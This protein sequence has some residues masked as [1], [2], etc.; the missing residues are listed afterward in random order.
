[1]TPRQRLERLY[2]HETVDRPGVYIRPGYPAGD[3]T[4]DR[5]R[6]YV[7]AHTE[8]KCWW[9]T[10]P[11]RSPLP[12]DVFTEP[13]SEDFER[14][15][16]VLHTRGGDLRESYLVSL[17]G[18]PGLRGEHLIKTVEDARRYLAMPPAQYGGDVSG[19][20]AAVRDMG[21][22]GLVQVDLVSNAAARVVGKM[23]S[24]TFALWSVGQ[25][26]LLHEL[27]R[28]EQ[29]DLLAM[30]RHL[31][32]AGVGPYFTVAGQEYIVPP[33]HGPADFH[34]FN[35]RYDAPLIEMIHEGG[36]LAHVHCHGAI[37]QVF[38]AFLEMGADVLHPFEPPPLGDITAAEAKA[39][40]AGRICLEGNIQIASLYEHTPEQI[41]AETAQLIADAFGDRRNLIVC[42]TASP[43]IRGAGEQCFANFKAMIDTVVNGSGSPAA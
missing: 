22:A 19:F 2:R 5:L 3:P 40:S 37:G 26:D 1:M 30:T 33:M 29:R 32:D 13:H 39:R 43:Y 42:P 36:G 23:G 27:M 4:Y 21:D 10:R 17:K 38:E 20:F 6:A 7:R 16:S 15:V 41:A 18:Q 35:V 14:Q 9:S 31:L 34:D 24:E 8:C 11:I 28:H 12:V 25:R